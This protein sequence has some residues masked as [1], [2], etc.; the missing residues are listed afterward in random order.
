[1]HVE[2][3]H[4]TV[5][6]ILPLT[7]FLQLENIITA[8]WL[9]M[10]FSAQVWSTFKGWIDNSTSKNVKWLCIW[11]VEFQQERAYNGNIRD[12][13]KK[14]DSWVWLKTTLDRGNNDFYFIHVYIYIYMIYSNSLR[15]FRVSHCITLFRFITMFYGT[16]SISWNILH[17]RTECGEYS[18]KYYQP[19]R[20]LL[21]IWMMLC[22]L[23][24]IYYSYFYIFW[25]A[26]FVH[27]KQNEAWIRHNIS[28]LLENVRSWYWF[29]RKW[30]V[31]IFDI[32]WID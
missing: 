21:W 26:H 31:D 11:Q 6:C 15:W 24:I 32:F 8:R 22:V 27:S 16:D 28:T 17:I 20:T 4:I 9:M 13:L 12:W 2:L 30:L 1:M 7:W 5:C 23:F 29:S 25:K 14:H 3:L 19:H 10:K 18:M